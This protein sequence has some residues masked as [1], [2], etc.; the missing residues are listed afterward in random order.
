M[1]GKPPRP[2][3]LSLQEDR[4]QYVIRWRQYDPVT[5]KTVQKS[6][7]TGFPVKAGYKRK[8]LDM[9]H[10]YAIVLNQQRSATP[11][12][13][14]PPFAACIEQWL[15]RQA[16]AVQENTLK[17]Y[18][19]YVKVHI[20]PA[21]GALPIRDV[22]YA[23]LEAYYHEKRKTLSVNSLKKHHV[24]IK[25]TLLQ[26]VRNGLI[27][28]NPAD[29]VAFPKAK[30]FE[31]HSFTMA[32][33]AHLIK[34]NEKTAEPARAA[35]MLAAYYG[36]RRSEACGLRWK[37]IDFENGRIT[38]A[39][40]VT[41]N[42]SL[43]IEAER[44]KTA[45]S[46][47][48]IGLAKSTVPYLQ[49]LKATQEATGLP[50]DKVCAWPD[51]RPVSPNYITRQFNKLLERAGLPRIRLHDLRHTVASLLAPRVPIKNLQFQLGHKNIQTTMDVYTHLMDEDKL[52]V[53]SV[54]DDVL[55][56]A[57]IP[58]R[59]ATTSTGNE[60]AGEKEI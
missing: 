42:G 27:A 39:N 25:G 9:M 28:S 18:R 48:T 13:D 50:L 53:S 32:Q 26:A 11:Q 38:V 52:A 58:N 22:T 3:S 44:T 4:G 6:K 45:Q 5:G 16:D 34:E 54:M 56:L 2:I 15:L 51:G 17:S 57:G 1:T 14:N 19:D 43:R 23:R 47:R 7:A 8:A 31:G 29:Y 24:V 46:H 33:L 12:P 20:A 40:T 37:D 41:E 60:R 49:A 55:Q 59:D 10:E 21:L 35:I 30:Q 36:L